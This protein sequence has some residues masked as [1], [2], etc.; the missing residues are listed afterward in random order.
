MRYGSEGAAIVPGMAAFWILM[1]YAFVFGTGAFIAFVFYYWFVV[2]PERV[3]SDRH[4]RPAPSST[5]VALPVPREPPSRQRT[6]S[7]SR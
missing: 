2:N 6:L 1:A 5:H 3:L 7:T 4:D